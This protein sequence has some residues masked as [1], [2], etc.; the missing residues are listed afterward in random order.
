M[1]WLLS[2]L[3]LS[4]LAV[5]SCAGLQKQREEE[6][7][8]F[9]TITYEEVQAAA[10]KKPMISA[11]DVIEFLRPRYLTPRIQNSVTQGAIRKDPVVYIN[12][13][14]VGGTNE[15]RNIDIGIIV[16]IHYLKAP[17]ATQRF[18]MGH[19]GGAIQISTR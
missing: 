7:S 4:L 5:L 6:A 19:E 16:S 1:K 2:C 14:R 9:Y 10:E 18:G 8:D 11:Y 15:L 3:V 17:E 12:N 13:V